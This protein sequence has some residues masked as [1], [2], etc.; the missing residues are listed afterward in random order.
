MIGLGEQLSGQIVA[1]AKR[2]IDQPQMRPSCHINVLDVS[3]CNVGMGV[4]PLREY[5]TKHRNS[6]SQAWLSPRIISINRGQMTS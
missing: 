4:W 3:V 6:K 1:K 5:A 2:T